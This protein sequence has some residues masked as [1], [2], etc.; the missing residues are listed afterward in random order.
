MWIWE[1]GVEEGSYRALHTLPK[2]EV[3][4]VTSIQQQE[5]NWILNAVLHNASDRPALMVRLKAVRSRSGDRI[6]PAFYSDN[7]VSLMPGERRSIRTELAQADA[8][9]EIPRI[10]LSGFNLD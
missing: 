4:A 10:V 1:R 9:G 7:F 5:G 8:R 2:V 6:L 3:N